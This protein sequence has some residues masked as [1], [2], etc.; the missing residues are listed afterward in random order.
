MSRISDYSR[1]AY[2]T[3]LKEMVLNPEDV[4]IQPASGAVVSALPA[5]DYDHVVI[6]SASYVS[7]FQNLVAWNKKKGV[8]DTV[9]TTSYIYSNYSGADNQEKIR[10]FVKDANA[11]WGT[12]WFLLGGDVGVVP[13]KTKYFSITGE[14]VPGD[15]Y[16]GDFDD[17]WVTEVFV[18]RAS[19][20]NTSQISTF[21]GKALTYEKTPPTASYPLK[22]FF[23]AFNLD[24][25]TPGERCKEDIDNLYM[26]ARFDPIDKVYDSYTGNH[27]DNSIAQLNAGHNLYNH[28]DHSGSDCMGVGYVNHG[29][30]LYNGDMDN[31]TNGNKQSILYSIGC[32]CG[33]FDYEDCIVEHFVENPNGG[34]VGAATNTRYGW[35]NYGSYNTLSML[36]DRAFFKSLF[37]D[38]MYH[39]GQTLA[40]SKNDNPPGTDDYYRY[41]AW[42]LSLLGEPELGIWTDTPTAM[43]VSH[44]T[45]INLGSQSFTVTVT[46]NSGPLANA[47][48]CVYKGAE[49]Y[50][51]GLTGTNGQKTFTINP[52]TAGTM[53]VTVTAQNHLPYE[54]TCTVGGVPDVSLTLN[55][56]SSDPHHRGGSL[57]YNAVF[58]NNTGSTQNVYYWARVTLPNSKTREA[59]PAELITVPVPAYTKAY[60]HTIPMNAPFGAYTYTGYISTTP[61]GSLMGQSSFTFNIQ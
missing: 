53:S 37:T 52:A 9:V 55:R 5:G 23:D 25:S 6:T 48:V 35:Y 28:I 47:L 50:A 2:E 41:I 16:Y 4:V 61:Y 51:Y 34:G 60:S 12:I 7:N 45:S 49:V 54:G 32:D 17:D 3:M 57:T 20:D 29:W 39:L 36:Y 11:T 22:A 18:G 30:L 58:T 38:N 44:P 15:M 13:V 10:N 14:N 26:P 24:S 42:E 33:A 31:L 46:Y 21:V 59:V 8:P 40:D 19:V 1:L 27:R 43:T 56:T